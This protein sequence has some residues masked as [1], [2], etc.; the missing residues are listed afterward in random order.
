MAFLGRLLVIS[1]FVRSTRDSFRS[2]RLLRACGHQGS[3]WE[4]SALFP[5]PPSYPWGITSGVARCGSVRLRLIASSSAT[6]ATPDCLRDDQSAR[7]GGVTLP[8]D[9]FN[10]GQSPDLHLL[11]VVGE[12]LVGAALQSAFHLHSSYCITKSSKCSGFG[13]PSNNLQSEMPLRSVDC[14]SRDDEAR[15][16]RKRIPVASVGG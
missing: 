7:D 5:E 4:Q 2:S 3:P 13:S 12:G 8:P 15:L 9:N 16:G 10:R 6:A 14:S 1:R 11:L